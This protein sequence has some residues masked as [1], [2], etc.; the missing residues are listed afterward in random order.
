MQYRAIGLMSGSSLDGLDIVYT[1]LE[2]TGGKWSYDIKAASCIEYEDEWMQKLKAAPHLSAYEYLLLHIAYGRFIAETVND[3]IAVNDLYHK[4]QLI[5]SHGHTVFHTPHL[6]MT[7]QLGDGATIAALTGINVVSDLRIMDVALGGTGA[8]IVP[9]GEKLLLKGYN[10]FLNIG[11]IA[12]IS[13]NIS[14]L[15][16][17]QNE[18]SSTQVKN[19]IA[20]DVCPA[21]RVL[22]MLAYKEGKA[23]DDKGQIAKSGSVNAALLSQLNDLNYYKQSYPK[24]LAN[25]FGTEII[26]PLVQASGISTAN[27]L[28]TYVEH[29]VQQ[30]AHAINLV[31]GEWAMGIKQKVKGNSKMLVTGGGVFNNFLIERLRDTFKIFNIEVIVPDDNL[32]QFK[33]AMI[34]AF[35]GIL[36]WR[37][38]DTVM[39][40]VTGASRSSIG[41]AVWIG[42]EA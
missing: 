33:E 31:N 39:N 3:F 23:Y 40:T 27:S 14:S 2:E 42:L 9:V 19:Y 20:F 5:A 6:G 13:A 11:G 26:F 25:D 1:E 35:L 15:H 8:P 28:R 30:V 22:N 41:G 17:T 24:S 21:S 32:V 10:Y 7:A 12:N 36:R 4:V 16:D 37:E 29:I 18:S 34:M 38:E